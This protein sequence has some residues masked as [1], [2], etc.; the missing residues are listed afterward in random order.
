M[1]SIKRR[2]EILDQKREFDNTSTDPDRL[3]SKKR[4]PGRLLREEKF[5]KTIN[6]EL[7]KLDSKIKKL[8]NEWEQ[9]HQE[10]FIY[11]GLRYIDQIHEIDI[12]P[13]MKVFF[14]NCFHFGDFLK[15]TKN[16]EERIK[17]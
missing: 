9:N 7:P 14:N 10:H 2:E 11:E 1:E 8:I 15:D 3:L 16:L 12:E 17:Q 13:K 4:D 6:K 5:R